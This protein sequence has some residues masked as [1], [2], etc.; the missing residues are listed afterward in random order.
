MYKE[1]I[2]EYFKKN[3]KNMIE[4]IC[5]LVKINS[6]KGPKEENMP[7]GKGPFMALK[8][9]LEIAE[10]M[11]FKTK[12]YD[13]YVGTVDLN[14]SEK[15]LDMLAHLDV[16][17]VVEDGWT[18]TKPFDPIVKDG[19]LY[20]RGTSD[21][22]GPAIAALYAMKAIKDLNIPVSKNVRLILGTDEECG[23]SDIAHYYKVEKEAPMTFSPDAE[24]PIINIEKGRL[25]NTFRAKYKE[26]IKTPRIVKFTSGTKSNVV[27]GKAYA[28]VD[29]FSMEEVQ[30]YA[31]EC[32]DKIKIKFNLSEKDGK[33]EI[34]A[35]GIDAHASTPEK[36]NNA[37]TGM[38]TLLTSMPFHKSEGFEKLC[39][40]AKLF[41]HG[42]YLGEKCGAKMEDEISG[43]LTMTLD[44]FSFDS[45]GFE[46]TFDSRAPICADDENLTK[47]LVENMK[48]VGIV[49]DDDKM[50]P[51]H[52]VSSDSDFVRTLLKCYE[53]YSGQKGECLAIGGGT[54]VH[55]LKNGVAFGC[56]MPGTDTNMHG[57]N[58][59]AVVEELLLSAKMFTQAI[60]DLC[61]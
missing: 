37:L 44:V 38:L 39:G 57:N 14:D 48:D 55:E 24:F 40:A 19:K 26:D 10:K 58:E 61:K 16:V 8:K 7:F 25:S 22:K 45:T 49:M 1:K 35:K 27:P 46:G 50:V 60:A 29:G 9:A 41:P 31:K 13:N 21:D 42:D 47:V 3:E 6:E 34:N 52:H 17:P 56:V 15:S 18:V 53:E 20:G 23:S 33:I 5:T 43:F 4:D 12:N 59:F 51:A 36:G 32:E 54:Y 28:L 2:E 11:G 30:K